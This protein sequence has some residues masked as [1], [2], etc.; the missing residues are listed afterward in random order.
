M[1]QYKNNLKVQNVIS[2]VIA[3]AAAAVVALGFSGVVDSHFILTPSYQ[4]EHWAGFW[5]GLYSGMAFWICLLSIICI[6]RNCLAL[7][8]EKKLKKMYVKENDERTHAIWAKS[9]GQSYWFVAGGMMTAIVVSGYFNPVVCLTILGCLLYFCLV[10]L[11]LK[12]YYSK[13][14]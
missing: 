6:V 12:L 5:N 14:I 7:R 8:S 9:G 3:L 4:N 13:K 1:E 11:G 2:G 10:R